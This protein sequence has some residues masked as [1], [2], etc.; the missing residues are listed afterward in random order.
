MGK[1]LGKDGKK[2]GIV[3]NEIYYET[4][5][6]NLVRERNRD[7]LVSNTTKSIENKA[8]FGSAML[9][10]SYL[11]TEILSYFFKPIG[12]TEMYKSAFA[13]DAH[14]AFYALDK[15]L[16][17]RSS[18]LPI[19]DYDFPGD[20][21]T[22]LR[23]DRVMKVRDFFEYPY[24]GILVSYNCDYGEVNTIGLLSRLL[25]DTYPQL[26]NGDKMF[27]YAAWCNNLYFRQNDAHPMYIEHNCQ[28]KYCYTTFNIDPNSNESLD[29]HHIGVVIEDLGELIHAYKIIM[30]PK[31]N[32]RFDC[33]CAYYLSQYPGI[34]Y[35]ACLKPGQ[36]NKCKYK[37]VD[38]YNVVYKN[39][40]NSML[41]NAYKQYVYNSWGQADH[42]IVNG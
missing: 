6:G 1:Y 15:K 29:D 11:N 2:I 5:F 3:G 34:I 32:R 30:F 18:I 39:I 4:K 33:D 20:E 25:K 31:K 23:T 12:S 38:T 8:K 22:F 40:R 19:G 16:Y 17:K 42:L 7:V 9:F 41:S 13:S 14:N 37:S 10:T 36:Y 24:H 28:K 21:D 27:L 35:G 26:E